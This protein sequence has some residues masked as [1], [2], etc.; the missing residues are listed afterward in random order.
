M[1]LCT[2]TTATPLW[3]VVNSISGY[4]GQPFLHEVELRDVHLQMSLSSEDG[5]LVLSHLRVSTRSTGRSDG[6]PLIPPVP[7]RCLIEQTNAA[8][9]PYRNAQGAAMLRKRYCQTVLRRYRY[10]GTLCTTRKDLL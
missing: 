5:S 1:K 4:T 8:Y 7:I 2:T 6:L 3:P 10:H 9:R